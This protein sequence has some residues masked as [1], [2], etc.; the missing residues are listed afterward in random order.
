MATRGRRDPD[1]ARYAAIRRRARQEVTRL[2]SMFKRMSKADKAGYRGQEIKQTQRIIEGYSESTYLGRKAS[3]ETRQTAREAANALETMIGRKGERG[4]KATQARRDR[5]FRSQIHLEEASGGAIS[6]A[7]FGGS[8]GRYHYERIFYMSTQSIWAGLPNQD[9][10]AAIMKA[11]GVSSL[12]EAYDIIIEGN[13]DAIAK[14]GQLGLS[15]D[16]W[17]YGYD[18]IMAYIEDAMDIIRR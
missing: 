4:R 1:A 5:I 8:A 13:A 7:R 17:E 2:E 18:E 11:L 14:M 16:G 3:G 12:E 6:S 10:D 15:G 9:R